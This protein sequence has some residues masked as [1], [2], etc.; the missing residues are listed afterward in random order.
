VT[1]YKF[2]G[3]NSIEEGI[4]AIQEEKLRLGDDLCVSDTASRGHVDKKDVKNLL[5]QVLRLT[6]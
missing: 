6:E 2:I 1:V 3:E 5:K 4:L